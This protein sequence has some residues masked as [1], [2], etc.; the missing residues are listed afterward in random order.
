MGGSSKPLYTLSRLWSQG[1]L[2]RLSFPPAWPQG[3]LPGFQVK[4]WALNSEP[5]PPPSVLRKGGA[6]SALSGGR[7]WGITRAVAGIGPADPSFR[8]C[9]GFLDLLQHRQAIVLRAVCQ[10]WAPGLC[11]SWADSRADWLRSGLCSASCAL[12]FTIP[13]ILYFPC[14]ASFHSQASVTRALEPSLLLL[15]VTQDIR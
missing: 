3:R 14:P 2:L 5:P 4:R 8:A 9:S 10:A 6:S 11:P 15:S 13:L 7:V 12:T 1:L